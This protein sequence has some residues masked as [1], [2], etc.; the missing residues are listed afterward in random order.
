MIFRPQRL[1]SF[2][3]T[4]SFLSTFSDAKKQMPH[5]PA[6]ILF[7]ECHVSGQPLQVLNI[8]TGHTCIA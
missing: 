7:H 8:Q 4:S 5:L 3:S 1:G 2:I 6:A